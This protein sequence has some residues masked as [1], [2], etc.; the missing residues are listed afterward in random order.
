MEK[1]HQ[2][3]G[4]QVVTVGFSG[5]LALMYLAKLSLFHTRLPLGLV[6]A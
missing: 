5:S 4:T 1:M 3:S 6:V 2:S